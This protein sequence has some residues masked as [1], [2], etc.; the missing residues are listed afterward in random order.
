MASFFCNTNVIFFC[1]QK[2]ANYWGDQSSIGEIS[3]QDRHP[4]LSKTLR[5]RDRLIFRNSS[6]SG[7]RVK[8][9]AI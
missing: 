9:P 3:H 4:W 8:F 6:N 2:F 1:Y 7:P 5:C